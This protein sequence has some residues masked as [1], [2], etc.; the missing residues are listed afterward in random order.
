VLELKL[1]GATG[2]TIPWTHA[3]DV[4]RTTNNSHQ[5][6]QMMDYKEYAGFNKPY[7]INV[8]PATHDAGTETGCEMLK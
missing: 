5:V 3:L 8:S 7:A 4:T 6:K 1:Y 2:K